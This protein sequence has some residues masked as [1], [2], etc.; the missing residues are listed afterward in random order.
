MRFR[1]LFMMICLMLAVIT[2]SAQQQDPV[3]IQPQQL[4]PFKKI[5][6]VV[7]PRRNTADSTSPKLAMI[8]SLD[9]NKWYQQGTLIDSVSMGKVYRMPVDK[10]HCLV[11]DNNKTAQMPVKKSRMPEQMPNAY[12]RRRMSHGGGSN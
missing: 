10:M 3:I 6:P 9:R 11:P 7:L 12:P 5:A 2:T 8:N 1:F 4:K